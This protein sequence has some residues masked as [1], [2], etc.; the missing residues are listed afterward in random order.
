MS[1]W[2]QTLNR[3]AQPLAVPHVLLTLV[4]GQTFFYLTDLLQLF[5]S[6][7]LL[8]AW[9]PV[10]YGEWWRLFTFPFSP[11]DVHWI[12]FAFAVYCLYSFGQA[13]EAEWGTLRFNFF[14]LVGWIFTVAAGWFA[15]SSPMSNGFIAGS[16]FLAFAVLNP[17]HVFYI[18][19]IL[20]IR[21]KF[22]AVITLALYTFSFATG[23]VST[24]LAI[25]A[26]L[27][28]WLVFLGPHLWQEFR[29][30]RRRLAHRTKHAAA[31]RELSAAGPRHVCVICGKDSDRHPHEDFRYRADDRC[32]CSEHVRHPLATAPT[33][34]SA[35]SAPPSR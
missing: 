25:A 27:G 16:I 1:R 10:L 18:Y 35:T 33:N 13:L 21:A 22:L 20:P 6:S 23:S 4:I 17:N 2:S 32:Y 26:A 34:T 30:G 12:F 9:T 7:R 14:L 31:E 8:F 15:P 19:F 29:S 5:D 3:W 24:R 28:N 11:P